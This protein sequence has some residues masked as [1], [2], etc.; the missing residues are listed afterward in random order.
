MTTTYGTSHTIDLDGPTHY[1]DLGGPASGPLIVA[2]HGLG[3]AAWNWLAIAPALTRQCRVLAIDL[4]GHGLTPSAGRSTSVRA[5]RRLLDRF[6]REVVG[7]P[8]ILMG[9]SMGGLI[10]ALQ[11]SARPD[12]VRGLV[13]V[14]PALPRPL[15]SKVDPRVA[16][17]FALVALPGLG[18]AVLTRRRRRIGIS[19][20]MR[21]TI[22][23]CTVDEKR[24][25]ADVLAEGERVLRE[26]DNAGF[27]ASDFMVAARSLLRLLARPAPVR[28]RLR[29]IQC[30]VQLIHGD[31]DRLV[32]IKVARSVAA[33]FPAWQFDVATD[34]GH[35]PMMEAAEWTA[36][37]VLDWMTQNAL[38]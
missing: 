3:G 26:R 27:N 31:H 9:N 13:L 35:V 10:S 36:E 25:P 38:V 34:I 14:D 8:V 5:N 18:E 30:P 29:K 23:L 37:R 21:D 4:A 24:V 20:Q 7:E 16:V 33:A 11:A 15:L 2:V 6:L 22:R 17:Q 28:R 32:S 12:S 1:L 19:Q